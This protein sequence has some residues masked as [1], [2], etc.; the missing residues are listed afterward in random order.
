MIC[1]PL[2]QWSCLI[3]KYYT[4][5]GHILP[6]FGWFWWYLAV[7]SHIWP[8]FIWFQLNLVADCKYLGLD[9]ILWALK[10]SLAP[11]RTPWIPEGFH[12]RLRRSRWP[13]R[14][15]HG[16]LMGPLGPK[17]VLWAPRGLPGLHKGS[18]WTLRVYLGVQICDRLGFDLYWWLYDAIMMRLWCADGALMMQ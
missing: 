12:G 5:F 10:G 8:T 14:I 16:H 6:I 7:F 4:V 1:L 2:H 9:V 18:P 13:L 3:V 15:S 17:G 11:K